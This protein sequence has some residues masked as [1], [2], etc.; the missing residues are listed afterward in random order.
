M[1]GWEADSARQQAR[2]E[3]LLRQ[4][5]VGWVCGP[6]HYI[7]VHGSRQLRQRNIHFPACTSG[8][9]LICVIN[10]WRIPP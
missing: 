9:T 5:M 4:R 3:R 10:H 2:V 1:E 7:H 8:S 6:R